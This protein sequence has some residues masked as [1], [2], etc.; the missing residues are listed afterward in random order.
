MCNKNKPVTTTVE[1][2]RFIVKEHLTFTTED[3]QVTVSGQQLTS[4]RALPCVLKRL[5]QSVNEGGVMLKAMFKFQ[6]GIRYCTQLRL[7]SPQLKPR[8]AV[9]HCSAPS[10]AFA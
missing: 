1:G 8:C 9:L 4:A 2:H 5:F 6:A 7:A 10:T 3:G